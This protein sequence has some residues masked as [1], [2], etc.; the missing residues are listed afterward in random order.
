MASKSAATEAKSKGKVEVV[1]LG[2]KTVRVAA[3]VLR[4]RLDDP[5]GGGGRRPFCNGKV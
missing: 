3:G 1:L 4:P 2:L 5:D